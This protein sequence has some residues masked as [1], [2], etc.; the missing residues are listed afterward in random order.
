MQV[1]PIAKLISI[2]DDNHNTD[3]RRCCVD[4]SEAW[5]LAL[6]IYG[7]FSFLVPG[8]DASALTLAVARM[9]HNALVGVFIRVTDI[10]EG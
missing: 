2:D 6:G 9:L 1:A 3:C 4:G 5:L 10:K 8:L 7:H